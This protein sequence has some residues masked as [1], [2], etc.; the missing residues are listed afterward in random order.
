MKPILLGFFSATEETGARV[1]AITEQLLF[2]SSIY[3][4]D[5][6]RFLNDSPFFHIG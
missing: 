5:W 3:F 2:L 1:I 6:W 4:R